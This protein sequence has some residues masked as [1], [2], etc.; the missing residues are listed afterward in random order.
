MLEYRSAFQKGKGDKD[1]GKGKGPNMPAE[2][3]GHAYQTGDGISICFGFNTGSCNKV[4][5]GEKCPRGMHVCCFKG[6]E[7]SHSLKAH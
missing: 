1:K 2:L 4:K 3:K 5:P 7:K 6:C